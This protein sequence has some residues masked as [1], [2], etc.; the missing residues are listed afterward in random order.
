M[1]IVQ[2]REWPTAAIEE[3]LAESEEE[4]FRFV[5]RAQAEWLSGAN[6]FSG[7]GEALF[8]VY[9]N[10]RLAA[11]GGINRESKRQG[12]LRRFYVRREQRR[13][14]IGRKLVQHVLDFA[15]GHYVRVGLCCDTEVADRF[16][17]SAGF[18]RTD[19][20]PGITHVVELKK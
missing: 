20:E 8:A 18:S 10:E 7:E 17:C 15:S 9:E 14:G 13:T 5:R 3:L 11:I 16:Y 4:G 19:S 6:T 1:R 2:I 12:R